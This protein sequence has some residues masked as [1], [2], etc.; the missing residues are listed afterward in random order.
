M[1]T[2]ADTQ[3]Y[4]QRAL[5]DLERAKQIADGPVPVEVRASVLIASVKIH[6]RALDR[7]S[8]GLAPAD[9]PS[10]GRDQRS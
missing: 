10:F 8:R 3:T 4:L 9:P 5:A 7:L 6:L 1:L 2:L